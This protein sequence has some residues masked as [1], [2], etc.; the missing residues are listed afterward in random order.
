MLFGEL[1]G[2]VTI[3]LGVLDQIDQFANLLKGKLKLPATSY[4]G[5]TLHIGL[6]VETMSPRS[7]PGLRKQ[8]YLLII[9]DSG[10]VA[11]CALSKR[12][13]GQWRCV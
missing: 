5:Q 3:A 11:V 13:N 2:C 6:A 12:P 9:P 8:S 10:H 7:P 1:L 4:E